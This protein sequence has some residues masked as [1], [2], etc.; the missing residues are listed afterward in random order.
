M[1]HRYLRAYVAGATVPT[2]MVLVGICIFALARYG[3]SW[4][5]PIEKVIIFPMALLPNA[6]GFW[7][8]LHVALGAGRRL[9]LGWHGVALALILFAAGYRLQQNLGMMIWPQEIL[10][11]G[12]PIAVILYYLLWQKAVGALNRL[13]NVA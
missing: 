10:W 12:L 7:N 3:F 5:R 13:F 2:M 6:W 1:D 8:M 4:D 11:Y 9:T